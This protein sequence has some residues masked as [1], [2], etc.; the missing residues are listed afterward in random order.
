LKKIDTSW[1]DSPTVESQV[2]TGGMESNTSV[3][4]GQGGDI[5]ETNKNCGIQVLTHAEW[6]RLTAV[7]DYMLLDDWYALPKDKR[8]RITYMGYLVTSVVPYKA[9]FFVLEYNSKK[10]VIEGFRAVEKLEGGKHEQDKNE[11]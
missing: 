1:L 8:P 3:G 6:A 7:G 11:Q 5:L 10:Y 4:G 9:G 2:Y